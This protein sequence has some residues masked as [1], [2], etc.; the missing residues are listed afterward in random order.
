MLFNLSGERLFMSSN[1]WTCD[2]ADCIFSLF[3]AGII[4]PGSVKASGISR[5]TKKG[6]SQYQCRNEACHTVTFQ[7]CMAVWLMAVMTY[8]HPVKSIEYTDK[9]TPPYMEPNTEPVSNLSG[10]P[11]FWKCIWIL[12]TQSYEHLA[13]LHK[14]AC[15]HIRKVKTLLTKIYWSFMC[16]QISLFKFVNIHLSSIYLS[17]PSVS[18]ALFISSLSGMLLRL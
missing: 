11:S 16:G 9:W 7:I 1:V 13:M 14:W 18:M 17:C 15:Y 8:H 5:T 3:R 2:F 4:H 10:F 12:H 6:I